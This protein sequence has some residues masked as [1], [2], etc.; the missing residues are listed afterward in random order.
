MGGVR[1]L[2]VR[3]LGLAGMHPL[4]ARRFAEASHVGL[5]AVITITVL[6]FGGFLWLTIRRL[7]RMDVA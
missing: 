7:R 4:D 2:S 1:L 3:D 6:V 5:D